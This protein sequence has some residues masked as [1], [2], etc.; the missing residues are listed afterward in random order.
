MAA[1]ITSR[2]V[3]RRIVVA[4]GDTSGRVAARLGIESLRMIAPIAP[5]A[6]LCRAHS[7]DPAIDGLEIAL[8]GGGMGGPDYFERVRLGR[9]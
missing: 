3:P 2:V 9:A 1:I 5:G 6:P 7:A 8:K 4:G